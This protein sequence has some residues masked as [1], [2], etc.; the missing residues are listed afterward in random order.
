MF[1]DVVNFPLFKELLDDEQSPQTE[2][3]LIW[4]IVV[5]TQYNISFEK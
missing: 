2:W 1:L 4:Y 5:K 3:F